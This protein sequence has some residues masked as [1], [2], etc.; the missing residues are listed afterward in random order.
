LFKEHNDM[1]RRLFALFLMILLVAAS[2][3]AQAPATKKAAPQ[4]T[5][6]KAEKK[7]S[8]IDLNSAS[9][10]D[11][12]T[13]PGIGDAYAQKIIDNRPYRAKNELTQ[14]K[15]IPQA[16]YDKISGQIIAKQNTA[17]SKKK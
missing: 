14:K 17:A 5:E 7:G 3:L 1:K 4:T 16:T 15:I 2:G 9:K 13:L 11:L 10:Q 12:M 8:Q 6:K